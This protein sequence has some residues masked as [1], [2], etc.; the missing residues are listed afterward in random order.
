MAAWTTEQIPPLTDTTVIVTGANSGLGYHTALALARAGADV[1]IGCRDPSR[2]DEAARTLRDASGGRVTPLPLDLADL[3][4]IRAFVARF[5]DERPRLDVLV[6][7]AG[8]M[9]LPRRETTVD[10]FE[11]QFGT[12]HL[13]HFALTG[14]LWP[15]LRRSP[16]ARVVSV[17]SMMAF[18]ARLDLGDLQGERRYGPL[19]AYNRTKLAN[20]YFMLELGRRARGT[21]VRSLAAHPGAAVTNLQRHA[22]GAS[23]RLIGQS[24]AAGA[25]PSLYAATVPDVQ[26][27]D[28]YGPRWFGAWGAPHRARIPG[29][30]RDESIA[31]RLWDLSEQL[32][33][34]RY[35]AGAA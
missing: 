26:S 29:L 18:A 1:V 31:A 17:S 4:S 23:I 12:N 8:V 20:L 28:Y 35:P 34:V 3:A 27:G 10:G 2:G 15:A 11:R 7:N 16:A 30:A 6:N 19:T 22:Y 24:A 14:L 21:S 25:L 33:G 5:T 32:T 13:G 9:A